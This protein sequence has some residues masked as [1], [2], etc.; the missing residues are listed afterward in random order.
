V[1]EDL[2]DDIDCL[3]DVA[4]TGGHGTSSLVCVNHCIWLVQLSASMDSFFD[5]EEEV[6][7]RNICRKNQ[8]STESKFGWCLIVPRNA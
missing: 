2:D 5:S 7:S 4:D 8:A 3:Y 1:D 6:D